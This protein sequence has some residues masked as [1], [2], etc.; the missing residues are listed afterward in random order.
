DLLLR[1]FEDADI[2][3]LPQVG[4]VGLVAPILAEK[5]HQRGLQRQHFANEPVLQV[6][7]GSGRS[8]RAPVGV[9]T[10]VVRHISHSPS[11][12]RIEPWDYTGIDERRW[13]T[14]HA[15]LLRGMQRKRAARSPSPPLAGDLVWT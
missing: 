3:I 12:L 2:D 5:L 14:G 6:A 10:T 8:L 4:D 9:V 7:H 11:F 1:R 13:K 15:I